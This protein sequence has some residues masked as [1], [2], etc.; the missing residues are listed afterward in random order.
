MSLNE[1]HIKFR[2]GENLSDAFLIQKNFKQ[3]DSSSS[4]ILNVVSEQRRADYSVINRQI[5]LCATDLRSG[6]LV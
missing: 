3:G 4:L 2:V 6:H 1:T 5:V